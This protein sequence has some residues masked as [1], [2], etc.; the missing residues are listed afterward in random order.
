MRKFNLKRI[1]RFISSDY[2]N[3]TVICTAKSLTTV[4]QTSIFPFMVAYFAISSES[5][6][7]S[8]LGIGFAIASISG[9]IG[10]FTSGYFLDKLFD[11]RKL[12]AISGI[13]QSIA[14]IFLSKNN[15]IHL[16]YTLFMLLGFANGMLGPASDIAVDRSR[17]N[18]INRGMAFT[19]SRFAESIVTII[20]FIIMAVMI[21]MGKT[22]IIFNI[23]GASTIVAVILVLKFS[24]NTSTDSNYTPEPS[25]KYIKKGKN[26]FRFNKFHFSRKSYSN[27]I[28][29]TI[30]RLLDE[31]FINIL[32]ILVIFHGILK[33]ENSAMPIDFAKIFVESSSHYLSVILA[34]LALRVVVFSIVLLPIGRKFSKL[35]AK[36]GFQFG[37][38]MYFIAMVMLSMSVVSGSSGLAFLPLLCIITVQVFSALANAALMPTSTR[39]VLESVD[40]EN[41]GI[42]LSFM[43]FAMAAANAI[44]TTVGGYYLSSNDDTYFWL[45]IAFL[46]IIAL[47][48]S[49][50]LSTQAK[51]L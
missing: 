39:V 4:L 20:T 15:S 48:I 30:F 14:A 12:F 10:A 2:S 43:G 6:S 50:R 33:L 7:A 46:C 51:N 8:I 11:W 42:A 18:N 40:K 38:L 13:I 3:F 32:I 27:G 36:K 23:G 24:S 9:V 17:I 41:Q 16:F 47:P 26:K 37:F 21:E 34:M 28:I 22:D 44:V 45:V 29:K 1:P 31:Q 25:G 5:I 19:F 35:P 49:A